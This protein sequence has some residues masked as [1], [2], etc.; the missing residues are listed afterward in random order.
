LPHL[1]EVIS[2]HRE[3][4]DLRPHPHPDRHLSLNN[5]GAAL[6]TRYEKTPQALQDLDEAVS[7]MR[8]CLACLPDFGIH[9]RGALVNISV[10]L[11]S[12]YEQKRSLKD[13]EEAISCSRELVTEYYPIGFEER[14]QGLVELANQ[15]Q[16]RFEVTGNQDD[17]DE[18]RQL[19]GEV[20][21]GV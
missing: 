8:E 4:L 10:A 19:W 17:L 14:K 7:L 13:L 20:E 3:A 5:L 16:L 15:L 12:L 2:L 21:E 9:R 1:D 11:R 6:Y 18:I